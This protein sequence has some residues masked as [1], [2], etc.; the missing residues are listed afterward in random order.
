MEKVAEEERGQREREVEG[1]SEE[2]R[3]ARTTCWFYVRSLGEGLT[4]VYC[5]P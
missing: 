1:H 2:V 4:E 5:L 3:E